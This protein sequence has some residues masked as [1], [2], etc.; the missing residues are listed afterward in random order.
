MMLMSFNQDFKFYILISDLISDLI[1]DFSYPWVC[2][3]KMKT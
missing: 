2:C 1:F 3:S